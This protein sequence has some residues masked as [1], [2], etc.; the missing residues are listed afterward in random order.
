MNTDSDI[1]PTCHEVVTNVYISPCSI[2]DVW[3]F[4]NSISFYSLYPI[5]PA[6]QG[7][8]VGIGI[9]PVKGLAKSVG[10]VNARKDMLAR[11][12]GAIQWGADERRKLWGLS[13]NARNGKHIER[14]N[15]KSIEYHYKDIGIGC[16]T[17]SMIDG[18]T[19][20][21]ND[22]S[23]QK[24]MEALSV[25]LQSWL[26]GS[27]I[28]VEC[29]F[30]GINEALPKHK[31]L[32]GWF[33]ESSTISNID[34][35]V[36]TRAAGAELYC[37]NLSAEFKCIP[38]PNRYQAALNIKSISQDLS[39]RMGLN[40]LGNTSSRKTWLF[41]LWVVGIIVVGFA[42]SFV[43]YMI[44]EED[45]NKLAKQN[46]IE[47]SARVSFTEDSKAYYNASNIIRNGSAGLAILLAVSV[48]LALRDRRRTKQCGSL[49]TE[50][51]RDQSHV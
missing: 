31:E 19:F 38:W 37:R 22:S 27:P 32:L 50:T 24:T 29:D 46:N 25:R 40:I 11:I 26:K 41:T 17:I 18:N 49:M 10:L 20:E 42:I 36:C 7:G 4:S 2:G 39:R 6:Q 9:D 43:A 28:S 47:D 21:F 16:I 23:D 30:Q 8:L 14:Q 13:I 48:P 33:W 3:I 35:I 44:A 12:Q 15:V 1:S 45:A 51:D 34:P 5:A